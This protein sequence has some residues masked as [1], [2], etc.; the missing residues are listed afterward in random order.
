VSFATL[1]DESRARSFA[2][3]IVVNGRRARMVMGSRDGISV[4]R[5][6]LGPFDSR[7]QAERA[8]MQSRLSYWVFEGAP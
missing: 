8:G 6:L 5:V 7:E 1:L 3:S 4:Y 2:D